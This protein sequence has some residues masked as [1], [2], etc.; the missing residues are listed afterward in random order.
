MSIRK[1]SKKLFGQKP[2]K[3]SECGA[4]YQPV[5]EHADIRCANCGCHQTIN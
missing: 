3:C 1:I 2:P 5:S 4:V